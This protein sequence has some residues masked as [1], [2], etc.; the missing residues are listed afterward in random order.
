[1]N[2][3]TEYSLNCPSCIRFNMDDS[4]RDKERKG[5]ARMRGIYDFTMATLILGVGV[6]MV[7][8]KQL[9]IM[10][11]IAVDDLV[12]YLFGSLCFLYGGFRLYRAIKKDY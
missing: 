11:V 6:M 7:F 3:E 1:M 2:S 8:A 5:Y 10:R 4:Y 12:R 9:N